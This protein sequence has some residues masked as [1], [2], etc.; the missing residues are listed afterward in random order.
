MC[1]SQ[2]AFAPHKLIQTPIIKLWTVFWRCPTAKIRFIAKWLL[3]I[4]KY[5]H[6]RLVWWLWRKWS[7]TSSIFYTNSRTLVM[8]G[9]NFSIN[10]SWLFLLFLTRI[11][12]M[13]TPASLSLLA[14]HSYLSPTRLLPLSSRSINFGSFWPVATPRMDRTPTMYLIYSSRIPY[15]KHH[16]VVNRSIIAS[17]FRLD[18]HY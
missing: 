6:S 2:V 14:C 9:L 13:Y 11:P 3:R 17:W 1:S 7:C 10:T 8:N 5:P 15:P 4:W 16:I 12:V 18:I